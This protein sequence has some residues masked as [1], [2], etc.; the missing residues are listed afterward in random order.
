MTDFESLKDILERAGIQAHA[1]EPD[2]DLSY[3]K[4]YGGTFPGKCITV[5]TGSWGCRFPVPAGDP[6][7]DHSNDMHTLFRFDR[8]GVLKD[9]VTYDA[10][11]Y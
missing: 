3:Y 2:P 4:K 10:A 5:V 8:E 9:V 7:P 6:K 11:D 1:E